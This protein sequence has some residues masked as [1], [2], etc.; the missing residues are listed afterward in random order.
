V[1]TF[2]YT[3]VAV[4]LTFSTGAIA[5]PHSNISTA[6]RQLVGDYRYETDSDSIYAVYIDFSVWRDGDKVVIGF[7][8]A[9]PRG[10]GAAPEGG[11]TG[12]ID[13]DGVLRFE[14]EDSF[15]NK[16]KGTFRRTKQ[17]Y[18]LFIHIDDLAEPRCAMYYGGEF[19]LQRISSKPHQT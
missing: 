15:F 18:K 7:Q 10:A 19:I 1:K 14:Y 6:E 3:L 11:G 12:H 8:G 16:G 4:I 2:L 9:H 5:G 13:S 17:G